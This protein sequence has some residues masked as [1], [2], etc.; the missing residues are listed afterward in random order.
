LGLAG[1][2][3]QQGYLDYS[4]LVEHYC[5]VNGCTKEDFFQDREEAFRLWE[6]RSKYEWTIDTSYLDTLDLPKYVNNREKVR[7]WMKEHPDEVVRIKE[8]GGIA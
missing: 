1:I 4:N 8:K 6:E 7:V 3:A 2:Q 5:V